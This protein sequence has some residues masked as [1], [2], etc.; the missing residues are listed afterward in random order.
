MTNWCFEVLFHSLMMF[1]QPVVIKLLNAFITKDCLLCNPIEKTSSG[2][3]E[4]K[5]N[6]FHLFHVHRTS[7]PRN[8][9][10]YP[11]VFKQVNIAYV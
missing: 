11:E 5:K 4:L 6:S 1:A 2:N 10:Q 8:T 3:L 7:A 9:L